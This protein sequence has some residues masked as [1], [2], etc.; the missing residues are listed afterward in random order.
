[1][2]DGIGVR[3]AVGGSVGGS[4]G[5]VP[6]LVARGGGVLVGTVGVA[7]FGRGVAVGATVCIGRVGVAAGGTNPPSLFPELPLLRVGVLVGGT[8]VG[9]SI[10]MVAV[11]V[12]VGVGGM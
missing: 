10:T 12:G 9:R 2:R 7:V 3:V 5:G 8:N 11:A 6:V 1:M 4:G